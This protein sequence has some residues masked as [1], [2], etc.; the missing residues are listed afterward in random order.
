MKI[1]RF[2]I[3]LSSS[4]FAMA[5][6]A[7]AQEPF[8]GEIKTFGMNFCPRGWAPANG[9]LLSISQ[10]S[11]LFSLLGTT[12]GG[13]GQTTFALPNFQSRVSIGTGQGVG[14]SSYV[15]GQAGGAENVTIT[16]SQLPLHAHLVSDLGAPPTVR[17]K[18]ANGPAAS[19]QSTAPAGDAATAAAGASQPH[20]NIKPY[21]TMNVCIALTGVFPSPN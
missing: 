21:L 11:A 5:A 7:S 6:S 4:A 13:N 12:F 14:L 9:Q 17:V 16:E 20:S 3:A 19:V 18:N 15:E 1:S 2:A 10:N 8:I